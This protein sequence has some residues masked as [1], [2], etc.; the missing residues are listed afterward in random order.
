MLVFVKGGGAG[1]DVAGTG[2]AAE[3]SS[4]AGELPDIRVNNLD[5][6]ADQVHVGGVLPYGHGLERDAS[7]V[8]GYL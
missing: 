3:Q 4:D 5:A 1:G 6:G 2:E 8:D 7:A